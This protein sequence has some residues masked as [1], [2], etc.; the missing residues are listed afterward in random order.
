MMLNSITNLNNILYSLL[1]SR[2]L[3]IKWWDSPNRHWEFKTP[4]EVYK[5]DPESVSSY[6]LGQL[7]G[8]YS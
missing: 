8:D 1:G 6:I 3:V 7:N 4:N 2:E 5:Y